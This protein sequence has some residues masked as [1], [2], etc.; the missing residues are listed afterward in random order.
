V[1]Q[2]AAKHL[3]VQQDNTYGCTAV[4]AWRDAVS[5]AVFKS[6]DGG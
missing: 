3:A 2:L 4:K 1:L 6:R 5:N